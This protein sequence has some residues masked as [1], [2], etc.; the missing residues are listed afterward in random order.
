MSTTY[1]SDCVQVL[2]HR[3]REISQVPLRTIHSRLCIDT[4]LPYI[5]FFEKH[6]HVIKSRGHVVVSSKLLPPH[7]DYVCVDKRP[8][9]CV[10]H[11]RSRSQTDCS[12]VSDYCKRLK[13]Q[14][15]PLCTDNT[16]IAI[17]YHTV[18]IHTTY[19]GNRWCIPFL[20]CFTLSS[21][22]ILDCLSE[23]RSSAL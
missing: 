12:G 23:I 4:R 10:N 21:K 19:P 9:I 8:R 15:M 6:T 18:V 5:L 2:M 17:S 13:D 7:N 3:V 20:C 22:F 11:R 14:V 1:D 16:K